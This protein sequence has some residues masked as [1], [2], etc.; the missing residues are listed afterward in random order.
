MVTGTQYIQRKQAKKLFVRNESI[1]PALA[2]I[3]YLLREEYAK[4]SCFC[5]FNSILFSGGVYTAAD[6]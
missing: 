1:F 2:R 3:G 6:V 4:Y 5:H